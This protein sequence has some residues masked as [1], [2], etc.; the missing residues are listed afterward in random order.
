MKTTILRAVLL[1]AVA[2]AIA[3]GPNPGG[4]DGGAGGGSGGGTGGGAGGGSGGGTGGGCGGSGGGAGGG[5]GGAGGGGGTGTC[6]T[7]FAGCS[8]Y[9]DR[10]ADCADRN[11]TFDFTPSPQCLR[12]KV[13][14][15]VTFNGSSN[16]HP[17]SQACGPVNAI[18]NSVTVT[19]VVTFSTAGD[20]GYYCDNH[21]TALGQAMAGS[22]RVDP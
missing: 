5:G 11:L 10:T 13:G 17:L 20:Y 12:V 3:C 8:T 22:I 19:R 7:A 6:A 15:T 4:N 14:Q 18:G 1:A 9:V 21:G 2:G 16:T